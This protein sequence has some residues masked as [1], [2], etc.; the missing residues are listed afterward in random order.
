M[1]RIA[2]LACLAV[3]PG[4]VGV[5]EER[6][7]Q[8]EEIGDV[9]LTTVVCA[10]TVDPG[11][12]CPTGN[13]GQPAGAGAFQLLMGVRTLERV[14]PPETFVAADGSAT[15]SLSP[16]FTAELQRLAPAPPG[17]RWVGYISPPFEY[18][19]ATSPASADFV[20][21]FA[22][23]RGGDGSPFQGPFRYR[24]VVGYRDAGPDVARPVE[25]G[26]SLTVG[27]G[28]TL[29]QDWPSE[30]ERGQAIE[31][32]TKDVGLL[33][34]AAGQVQRGTS[35]VI[36]FSLAYNGD[37]PGPVLGLQAS[38]SIPSGS[39]VP[40]APSF[41]P[42]GPGTHAAGVTV[43][44]PPT[45]PP[46]DYDVTLTARVAGQ[47]RQTTARVTV[48]APSIDKEA[49]EI[50]LAPKGRL[51]LRTVIAKGMLVD[52][53][54]DEPCRFSAQL[55][56]GAATARRLGIKGRT[57]IAGRGTEKQT[58]DGI[59]S[60]RIYFLK[61]YKPKL[62]KLRSITVTLRMAARDASGNARARSIRLT[63]RR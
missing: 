23:A 63:L 37:G 16:T 62:K 53:G 52:A 17:E 34:G 40:V 8:L 54:C 14:A 47:V 20:G 31:V 12:P 25:C 13:S 41:Q 4:C 43:T 19:P 26:E 59:R 15:L 24:S 6:T 50:S 27:T 28:D 7:R 32:P 2:L 22:L 11:A 10:S 1:R 48:L 51:D 18:D 30:E 61:P 21:R 9:E 45:A 44:A 3:L 35:T 39:A 56:V 46:G 49:P 58:L 33:A 57:R 60:V 55:R 5:A 36:G 42:P 29:C 38:T